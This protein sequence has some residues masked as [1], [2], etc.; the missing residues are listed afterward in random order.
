MK[1]KNKIKN[2]FIGLILV[3]LFNTACYAEYDS[4]AIKAYN[5]G[6]DLTT[7]EK[8]NEAV[9]SL[10]DAVKIEP[11]FTDAYYNLGILYQY[12]G[13]IDKALESY[14][15]ILQYNPKDYEVIQKIA[16]IYHNKGNKEKVLE[17]IKKIPT[18]DP[19]Y[20]LIAELMKTAQSVQAQAEKTH[21]IKDVKKCETYSG[22]EGPTG[23]AR[24]SKGNLYV[25]NFSDNS[26]ISI[27]NTGERK[28]LA[29]DGVINGPLGLV[30][31]K[32]DNIYVANYESNQ[33]V[34]IPAN[35]RTPQVLPFIVKKPYFLML[36][37]AGILYVTE[38]GTNSVSQHYLE[39][40]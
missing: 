2:L 7:Q 37:N 21:Q 11:S 32:N 40:K 12:L 30:I 16:V 39:I 25:A 5:N 34:V 18:T 1:I 24:D 28:V 29:K 13:N 36:D 9:L 33:I 8:Y 23:I 19:N 22:F 20:G 17:Y 27:N 6:I 4:K 10:E 35:N 38:Q 14:Q 15:A 26:I 3:L 31:D